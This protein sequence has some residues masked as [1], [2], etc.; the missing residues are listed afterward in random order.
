MVKSK[1]HQLSSALL[2]AAA[3]AW[4]LSAVVSLALSPPGKYGWLDDL[5]FSSLLPGIAVVD[6]IDK[7]GGRHI[8]GRGMNRTVFLIVGFYS[9]AVYTTL[10]TGL[11]LRVWAWHT[12]RMKG[13]PGDDRRDGLSSC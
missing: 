7:I 4:A 5:Y 9:F 11:G 6:L 1:L 3:M 10:V 8:W 12:Q 2:I 13:T